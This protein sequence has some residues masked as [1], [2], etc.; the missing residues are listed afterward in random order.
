MKTIKLKLN[1]QLKLNNTYWWPKIWSKALGQKIWDN[2]FLPPKSQHKK[3]NKKIWKI[4][5][6]TNKKCSIVFNK[7]YLNKNLLPKYTL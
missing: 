7:T 5:I 2:S 3:N 1:C 6:K 4:T